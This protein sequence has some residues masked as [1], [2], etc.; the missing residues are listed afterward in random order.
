MPS[1]R[2]SSSSSSALASSVGQRQGSQQLDV[3]FTSDP[4]FVH[5]GN[6]VAVPRGLSGVQHDH[7][8]A[9]V[10]NFRSDDAYATMSEI[11]RR[12]SAA[13]E[14]KAALKA[15]IAAKRTLESGAADDDDY[16]VRVP[17]HHPAVCKSLLGSPSRSSFID[18][19]FMHTVCINHMIIMDQL[20][21]R[22]TCG[23]IDSFTP[24]CIAGSIQESP[25]SRVAGTANRAFC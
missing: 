19:H 4:L 14:M 2:L 12:A 13:K 23:V 10:L 5:A 6:G 1:R 18:W 9:P 21:H 17:K 8:A 22:G 3:V 15:Q 11:S 25:A 7:S 24:V 16:E 20:V